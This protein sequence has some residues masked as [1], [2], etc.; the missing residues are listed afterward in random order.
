MLAGQDIMEKLQMSLSFTYINGKKSPKV[1]IKFPVNALI[2]TQYVYPADTQK[3]F[4]Y[5]ELKP[6]ETIIT[7][8]QLHPASTFIKG[9]T[10]LISESS[11]SNIYIQ[12]TKCVIYS[13]PDTPALACITNLTKK[14][15]RGK[16]MAQI[17]S[18]TILVYL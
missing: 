4:A 5:I 17:E 13:N 7:K 2:S 1:N 6:S 18:L 14:L 15:Y 12:P 3:C 11:N 9:Q 10:V 16:I 8:L